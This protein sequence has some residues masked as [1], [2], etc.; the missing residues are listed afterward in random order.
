MWQLFYCSR[1]PV[2]YWIPVEPS[3]G[4]PKGAHVC[5]GITGPRFDF[6]FPVVLLSW[7]PF[8]LFITQ[9]LISY[10]VITTGIAITISVVVSWMCG[11]A[12]RTELT[13]WRLI[14]PFSTFSSPKPSSHEVFFVCWPERAAERP[15]HGVASTSPN[16]E[17][18]SV[19]I[20][21]KKWL[22]CRFLENSCDKWITCRSGSSFD[23]PHA[24]SHRAPDSPAG[25]CSPFYHVQRSVLPLCHP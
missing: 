4:I 1:P 14:T 7:L 8:S 22:D 10:C 12:K 13:W 24:S 17:F 19:N 20:R 21:L 25:R 11:P 2:D 18:S 3:D 5:S 16:R 6:Y 9:H 15:T 23:G